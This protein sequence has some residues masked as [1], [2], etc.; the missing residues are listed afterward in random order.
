MADRLKKPYD[1]I[2]LSYQIQTFGDTPPT[3]YVRAIVYGPKDANGNIS[4]I[5]GSP[6]AL[7]HIGN[8]LYGLDG[9]F[10]AQVD[11]GTYK[12][13]YIPYTDAGYTT[14]SQQY[15]EQHETITI[16]VQA[17][18]GGVGYGGFDYDDSHLIK[19]IQDKFKEFDKKIKKLQKDFDSGLKIEIP[20]F[21]NIDDQVKIISAKLE[22]K[23]EKQ[24]FDDSKIVNRID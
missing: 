12:V 19:L 4:E 23:N 18:T 14:Q 15:G 9:A 10:Q 13:I 5:S 11:S 20:E 16:S 17:T 1:S 21:K 8:N 3:L 2:D 24:T 6:F 7:D 22:N